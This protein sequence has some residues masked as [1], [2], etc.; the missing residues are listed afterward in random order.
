MER[1]SGPTAAPAVAPLSRARLPTTSAAQPARSASALARGVTAPTYG[2]PHCSATSSWRSSLTS[3][4]AARS[5][6]AGHACSRTRRWSAAKAARRLP[7]HRAPRAA[8]TPL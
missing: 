5:S 7:L 8:T 3:A 4:S 2:L 1:G 6:A